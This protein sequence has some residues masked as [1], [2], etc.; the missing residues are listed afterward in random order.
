MVGQHTPSTCLL[1]PNWV[2]RAPFS[3]AQS[4]LPPAHPAT[5]A[6]SLPLPLPE[7]QRP[8]APEPQAQPAAAAPVCVG[9][10][11]CMHAWWCGLICRARQRHGMQ[12]MQGTPASC[13]VRA[14][15][16]SSASNV[17]ATDKLTCVARSG[18]IVCKGD[19]DCP[20][21]NCGMKERPGRVRARVAT[22]EFDRDATHLLHSA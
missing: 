12:A 18:S 13:S 8:P 4:P 9:M 7:V 21:E 14:S 15:D 11:A 17:D 3:T 6:H 10:H 22:A 19:W 20:G 5:A 1:H 16:D 2:D